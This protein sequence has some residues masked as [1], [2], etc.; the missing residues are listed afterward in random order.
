MNIKG[1]IYAIKCIFIAFVVSLVILL[2]FSSLSVEA[3]TA[4][5][6]F[7]GLASLYKMLYNI[8]K[9]KDEVK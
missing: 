7:I 6:L 5:F 3:L 8:G 4:L 9:I 1:H 2:A